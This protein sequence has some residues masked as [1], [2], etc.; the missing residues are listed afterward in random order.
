MATTRRISIAAALA[1]ILLMF[2]LGMSARAQDNYWQG[3]TLGDESWS[4]TGNWSLGHVPTTG[5]TAVFGSDDDGKNVT[6]AT[7]VT[8]AANVSIEAGCDISLTTTAT[9][10]I[11]GALNLGAGASIDLAGLTS[12]APAL[13]LNAAVTMVAGQ[14]VQ[15]YD[16]IITVND[17]TEIFGS[18]RSKEINLGVSST[19]TMGDLRATYFGATVTTH[20]Y[21]GTGAFLTPV[22]FNDDVI[23]HANI[24]PAHNIWLG[25]AADIA[26]YTNNQQQ[27]HFITSCLID[28]PIG[29]LLVKSVDYWKNSATLG[30][31]KT[32]TAATGYFE[33]PMGSYRNSQE[34]ESY[35]YV[36]LQYVRECT[37]NDAEIP[38]V[39]TASQPF[40]G[41]GVRAVSLKHPANTA[42]DP[43]LRYWIVQPIG[44]DQDNFISVNNPLNNRICVQMEIFPNDVDAPARA[45]GARFSDNYID[46]RDVGGGT[47]YDDGSF[48]GVTTNIKGRTVVTMC[49][50]SGFGDFTI[51]DGQ[52]PV[53]V[54]LTSFSARVVDNQVKLNWETATELNNY[55]FYVERS[56][57]R[58]NWKEIG[59]VPGSG[60]SFSPKSYVYFDELDDELLRLP[61]LSYRLR[62]VDRD[63]TT[64]YSNIVNVRTGELPESVELYAAYPNPFNPAT[65]ISFA[66]GTPARVTLKVYNTLGQAVATILSGSAM[67]AGLHTV[68][69]DGAR[70]PSGVYMAVL[71]VNGA[72]RHQKLV[73]NK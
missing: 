37:W 30:D 10:T 70:L 57:V 1:F 4:T 47:F 11:D 65:T 6:I 45:Y 27:Y 29:G 16:G 34:E 12:P 25:A 28:Y 23:L 44:L 48:Y 24:D 41:F 35:L 71:D 61:E 69:F 60:T 2:G 14:F 62:Q 63:G 22:R 15:T 13:Q 50:T 26:E 54:E 40:R 32:L 20:L 46:H 43:V 72:V 31:F 5:E 49:P 17:A 3:P 51:G 33:F 19:L 36:W 9:L 55:G 73:L 38:W 39:P 53:P 56:A 42:N 68:G 7:A 58:E 21:R 18:G 8:T 67:D 66:I 59:F 64:D 52:D